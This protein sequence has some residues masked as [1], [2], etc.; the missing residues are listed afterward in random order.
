MSFIVR[1]AKIEDG[2]AMIQM[3]P[4]LG[5]FEIPQSRVRQHLWM[6][7]DK[8]LRRW[9]ANDAENCQITVATGDGGEVIGLA[10]V[11]L[12]PELLSLEPSAHL[13][14]LAVADGVEGRG[15]GQALLVEAEVRAKNEGA[16]TMTL[17]A[18]ATNTRAC[19]FYERSGYN[20]ELRR[21]IK[22]IGAGE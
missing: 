15:I 20:A 18:F 8:L 6:H 10:I 4:R 12:R 9:L 11:T 2:D 22:P 13:E 7:D 3:M 21:Y 19:A 5:S 14:A 1:E 16:L 17:H